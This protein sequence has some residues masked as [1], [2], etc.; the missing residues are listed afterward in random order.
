MP[1]GALQS[2]QGAPYL[3]NGMPLRRRVAWVLACLTLLAALYTGLYD[4]RFLVRFLGFVALGLGFEAAY[5]LLAAGRLGVR[6]GSAAVTAALLACSVPPD[7]PAGPMALAIG[8]AVFF[9]RMPSAEAPLRLNPMLV[10]RLFL[11]LAFNDAI[12]AWPAPTG[13]IDALATATPL[14]LFHAEEAL[15]PP[16]MLACGRLRGEWE[17]LYRLVPGGPGEA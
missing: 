1:D 12:V 4:T 6:S 17:S 11:M 16:G 5:E 3:W 2:V 15:T 9:V 10:G 14:E 8:L 7:M 13:E